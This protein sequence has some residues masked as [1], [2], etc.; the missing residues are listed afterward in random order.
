MELEY[1]NAAGQPVQIGQFRINSAQHIQFTST[2]LKVRVRLGNSGLIAI[3]SA[4]LHVEEKVNED[5]QMANASEEQSQVN[6]QDQQAAGG[7]DA[8]SDKPKTCERK[9]EL[10]LETLHVTGRLNE[11]QLDEYRNLENNLIL[12][13]KNW[14]ERMDA[15]N[16]LEEYVY[17]WRDRLDGGEYDSYM[18]PADKQ[19]FATGLRSMQDWLRDDEDSGEM[20]PRQVYVDKLNSLR[21]PHSEPLLFRRQEHQGRDAALERLGKCVQMGNKLLVEKDEQLDTQLVDRLKQELSDKQAWFE[22]THQSLVGFELHQKPPISVHDIALQSDQ[23]EKAI[24]PVLEQLQKLRNERAK[25][26]E[27]EAKKKLKEQEAAANQANGEVPTQ[28]P[29]QS[30]E[31]NGSSMDVEP[32][33]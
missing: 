9:I 19:H 1:V 4:T 32:N 6:G 12:A 18:Q 17:E 16:E 15:R 3:T 2:K 30:P 29:P 7:D 27:E 31:S 26:L 8:K 23:L 14:R 33:H 25:Q 21:H 11:Q 10:P 28:P 22:Q 13:D 5:V 20:Q 24:K